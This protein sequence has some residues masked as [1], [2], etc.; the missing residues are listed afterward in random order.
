MQFERQNLNK[1]RLIMFHHNTPQIKMPN[2]TLAD[3]PL[4]ILGQQSRINRLYTQITFCYRLAEDDDSCLQSKIINTLEN[5]FRRLSD[6]FPWITGQI[7]KDNGTF[8]IRPSSGS[9]HVLVK[10]HTKDPSVPDWD[11]LQQANFPFSMLD[12]SILAPCKTLESSSEGLLVFL[13]Q[14]NFVGG[15]G[16]LLT[17]NGQHGAMDMAAFTQVMYLFSKACRNEQFTEDELSIGNMDRRNVIPLLEDQTHNTSDSH[18]SQSARDE[19]VQQLPQNGPISSSN[20]CTWA[21]FSFSNTNLANLKSQAT[22][23]LPSGTREFISTDDALSAFLWHSI[24]RIRL[25]RYV[26]RNEMTSNLETTLSRNVDVRR[27][28]SI[29]ASYPGLVTDTTVHTFPLKEVANQSLG[30]LSIELRSAL[31]PVA[32]SRHTREIATRISREKKSK[33]TISVAKAYP[34]FEVRLSS[35]AKE[36]CYS[37][38]FGFGLPVAVRRPRFTEGSRDGLVYFLP[39]SLDGEIVVGICLA[40]HDMERLRTD[41]E[42]VM[43]GTFLG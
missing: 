31:D 33:D 37:L 40:C 25:Q 9:P 10:D 38:D 1:S 30:F 35:W 29:S 7:T 11:T 15:R 6:T 24:S 21:Y 18:N 12:G 2:F 41:K 13:V 3:F 28:L 22:A 19:K 42:F 32:L 36:K 17:L 20:D 23:T 26:R 14:A 43:F 27:H 34:E 4:D 16:L 8:K 5:G 39:R